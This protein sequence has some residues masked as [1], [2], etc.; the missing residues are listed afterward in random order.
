[1][2]DIELLPNGL[3]TELLLNSR[4]HSVADLVTGIDDEVSRFEDLFRGSDPSKYSSRAHQLD[5]FQLLDKGVPNHLELLSG[6]PH[7][8][9]EV[10]GAFVVRMSVRS[11]HTSFLNTCLI[12]GDD[13][14]GEV[15]ATR[16]TGMTTPA[17]ESSA[18]AFTGTRLH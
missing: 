8:V 6:E 17:T 5:G 14:F 9:N 7:F 4:L 16:A 2:S 1:L 13:S 3:S 10:L 12:G 11:H 15:N 18:I